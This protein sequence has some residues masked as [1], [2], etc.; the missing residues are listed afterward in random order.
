[1]AK[2]VVIIDGFS[3]VQAL[4]RTINSTKKE[5]GTSVEFEKRVKDDTVRV[6]ERDTH[7]VS[8]PHFASTSTPNSEEHFTKTNVDNNSLF[9]HSSLSLG[10]GS[11]APTRNVVTCYECGYKH[12]IVGVDNHPFCP[13]CKIEYCTENI[14]VKGACTTDIKTIGD[15]VLSSTA[16]L[17]KKIKLVGANIYVSCDIRNCSEIL[18]TGRILLCHGAQFDTSILK[19]LIVEIPKTEIIDLKSELVCREL[20]V[21]GTLVGKVSVGDRITIN[22]EG[23]LKG[24]LRASSLI[25]ADGAGLVGDVRLQPICN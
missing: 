16:V 24:E 22:S 4:K 11:V 9:N 15:I 2:K 1:M 20:I 3:Q 6:Y 14:N 10:G 13:R 12:T 18:A 17:S 23:F 7:T 21:N 5:V 19:N 25:M 8:M